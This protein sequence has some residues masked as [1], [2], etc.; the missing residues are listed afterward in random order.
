MYDVK[1]AVKPSDKK[2]RE[3]I[4]CQKKVRTNKIFKSQI[5]KFWIKRKRLNSLVDRISKH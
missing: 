2:R 3:L 5:V 4:C 1:I